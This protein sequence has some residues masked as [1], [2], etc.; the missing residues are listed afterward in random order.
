VIFTKRQ[1]LYSAQRY[2]AQL[3]VQL[4]W[5]WRSQWPWCACASIWQSV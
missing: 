1:H 2:S 3:T 4:G 5:R